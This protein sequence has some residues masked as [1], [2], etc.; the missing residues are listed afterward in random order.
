M[1]KVMRITKV[2]IRLL[3]LLVI[4]YIL[5][6][7]PLNKLI[8]K[9]YTFEEIIDIVG[10]PKYNKNNEK[11]NKE[12]YNKYN[13][14]VYSSPENIIKKTNLQRFKEVKDKGKY[15]YN[16][17]KGEFFILGTNYEGDYVYNVYFPVDIV[18]ESLPYKWNFIYYSSFEKSWN[19]NY[20]YI[21]QVEYMKETNLLFDKIDLKNKTCDSYN[22]VEYNISPI[23][24]GLGK[25]RLNTLA[26][27]KTMGII[28]TKRRAKD[29]TIRDS[30]FATKPMAASANIKSWIDVKDKVDMGEDEDSVNIDIS[31]GCNAINLSKYAK[32]YHIKNITSKIYIND[33]Y[34]DSVSGSKTANLDKK[35]MFAI[36]REKDEI[37]AKDV[38]LNIRVESYMY[39]EFL[40]DGLMYDSCSREILVKIAPKKLVP[41]NSIDIKL[42]KV[43][44]GALVVSPLV[45]TIKTNV[46]NSSGIIEK[47]RYLALGLSLNLKREYY[48]SFNIYVNNIKQEYEIIKD[49][50]NIIILKLGV[51]NNFNVSITTWKTLRD[52]YGS[53]FDVENQDIARRINKPNVIK[54]IVKLNVNEINYEYLTYV[55]TVD[56]YM[57]NINYKYFDN[58]TNFEELDNIYEI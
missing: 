33:K 39:T 40:I 31:F 16:K 58:V 56:Y 43:H 57:D 28:S 24:Y 51:E 37:R 32:E 54:I 30:V 38:I 12:I 19:C 21:E 45:Q 7:H 2:S 11:I 23:K 9:S 15:L 4:I 17:K 1:C 55:D 5:N 3:F 41:I 34:V 52:T 14:F 44:N 25:F 29:G 35:I 49:K 27:W 47:G 22:F 42:L 48:E 18:P 6:Y 36:S 20:L 50:N 10:I 8:G 53:I 13:L 46:E 26:T